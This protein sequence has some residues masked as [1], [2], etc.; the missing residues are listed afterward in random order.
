VLDLIN[1]DGIPA[2]IAACHCGDKFQAL[3][4]T[5]LSS[6]RLRHE[7]S[8]GKM[9]LMYNRSQTLLDLIPTQ[10]V[11]PESKGRPE[12]ERPRRLTG[13]IRC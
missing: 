1:S 11:N 13:N 10:T 5:N 6:L 7:R 12:T 2:E 8:T 9:V 4:H 3:L